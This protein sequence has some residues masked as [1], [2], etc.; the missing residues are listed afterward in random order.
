MQLIG[1]SALLAARLY[2]KE[3]LVAKSAKFPII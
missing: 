1:K 2:F 3:R